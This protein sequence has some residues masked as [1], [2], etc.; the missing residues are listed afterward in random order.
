[1]TQNQ[2]KFI[3]SKLGVNIEYSYERKEADCVAFEPQC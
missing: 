2:L 1:M 3:K